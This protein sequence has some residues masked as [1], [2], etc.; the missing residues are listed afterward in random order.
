[1]WVSNIYFFIREKTKSF[2]PITELS[3][4]LTL[5]PINEFFINTLLPITEFLPIHT[6]DSIIELCPIKHLLPI[7]TFFPNKTFLPN[8]TLYI[9]FD[10]VYLT[11]N[12]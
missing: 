10:Q 9:Y 11:K 8:L 5:L 3:R 6:F 4:I 12:Q 1:M 7:F 2:F